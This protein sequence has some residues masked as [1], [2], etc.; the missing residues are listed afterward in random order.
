MRIFYNCCIYCGNYNGSVDCF[1]IKDKRNNKFI[2]NVDCCNE[3]KNIGGIFYLNS[4]P[5]KS[6]YLL[7]RYIHIYKNLST[8]EIEEIKLFNLEKRTLLGFYPI[9]IHEITKEEN[10]EKRLRKLWDS[11]CQKE[12]MEPLLQGQM[13]IGISLFKKST[14]R[15]G[16]RGKYKKAKNLI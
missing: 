8:T 1:S 4:V 3:C 10:R 15:S 16:R 12:K 7:T 6:Q 9:S 13:Q 5:E 14:S 11:I 2:V